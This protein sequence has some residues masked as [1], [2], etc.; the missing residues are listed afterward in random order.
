[1][2]FNHTVHIHVADADNDM[3]VDST[4]T[5]EDTSEEHT[6]DEPLYPGAEVTIIHAN[7]M[8]MQYA[9]KRSLT[10]AALTN[11]LDLVRVLL[12]KANK[13]PTS[14]YVLKKYFE[15][16]CPEVTEMRCESFCTMCHSLVVDGECPS[17][18][19]ERID[20]FLHIPVAP[21]LKRMAKGMFFYVWASLPSQYYKL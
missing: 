3:D 17:K 9:L 21:Q 19:G 14:L 13:L 4:D 15:K 6:D 11:L 16:K 1:M 18:C 20:D 2:Y 5:N 10:K 12:P 8:L 7:L